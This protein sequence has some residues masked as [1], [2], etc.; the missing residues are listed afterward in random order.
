MY[1]LTKPDYL[2]MSLRQHSQIAIVAF[3][4]AVAMAVGMIVGGAAMLIV[5][6]TDIEFKG[7]DSWQEAE[8]TYEYD[9]SY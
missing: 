1:E 6:T 9:Y 8:E 4:I 2:K 5:A 3:M 7:A